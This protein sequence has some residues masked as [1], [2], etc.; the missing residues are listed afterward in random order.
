MTGLCLTRDEIEEL[1]GMR[2]K[3]SQIRALA[4][5]GIPFRVR[6]DGSPAVLR[7]DLMPD[8]ATVTA[9]EPDFSS[10]NSDGTEAA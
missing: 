8:G 5:M 7:C 4:Q 1:T 9:S 6:P 3:S 10:M 2:R